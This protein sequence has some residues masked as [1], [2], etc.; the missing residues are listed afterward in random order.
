MNIELITELNIETFSEYYYA[1][2]DGNKSNNIKNF[3]V[4][5]SKVFKFP[6]YFGFNVN[7]LQE[8]LNDLDWLKEDNYVLHI[9]NY[10][11]FLSEENSISRI[12]I[13]ELLDSTAEEW[14]NVPN[15]E[16][17][18]EFRKKADFKIIIERTK[19][20]LYDIE[21]LNNHRCS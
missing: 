1:E 15:F 19:K 6:D 17:E 18:N 13:L 5:I 2:L 12:D 11:Q 14:K 3:L 7:A 16:G 21:T 4:E 20:S 9:R 10:D 8:C